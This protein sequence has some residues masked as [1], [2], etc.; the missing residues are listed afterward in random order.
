MIVNYSRLATDSSI[1]GYWKLDGNST[2]A[3]GV[4]NGSDVGMAYAS[5]KYNQAG[6]FNGTTSR[7]SCGTNSSLNITGDITVS[8]WI[9]PTSTGE[10]GYGVIFTKTTGGSDGYEFDM[11]VGTGLLFSARG[12]NTGTT[13]NSSVTLNTWQH[14]AAVRSG[15]ALTFYVN[16]ASV[17]SSSGIP[18]INTSVSGTAYI[19]NQQT[20]GATFAGY[21]DE[22]AVFSK[23][24]SAEEIRSLSQDNVYGELTGII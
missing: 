20:Q 1:K 19:G 15:T 10:G 24:L 7:V 6:L 11:T 17:S 8:A 2:D 22:V 18:T 9:Y 14:V 12:G 16:G 4:N 5:G 13:A 23:A 3:T 21:L